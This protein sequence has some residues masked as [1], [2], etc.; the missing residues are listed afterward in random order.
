MFLA[1][2]DPPLDYLDRFTPRVSGVFTR[3]TKRWINP[4]IRLAI[5]RRYCISLGPNAKSQIKLLYGASS[6][7]FPA[8]KSSSSTTHYTRGCR[9]LPFSSIHSSTANDYGS[10]AAAV[11]QQ[12]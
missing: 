1:R 7:R 3:S 2:R 4:S 5:K 11:A 6:A 12:T 8:C 10:L 9:G